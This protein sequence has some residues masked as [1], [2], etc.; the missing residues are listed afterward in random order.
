MSPR[1]RAAIC[2]LLLGVFFAAGGERAEADARAA[3]G[4]FFHERGQEAYRAGRFTEAVEHFLV[5]YRASPNPR[6][7]FNLAKAALRAERLAL[8]FTSFEE[9]LASDDDDASRREQAERHRAELV[10]RLALV[11]VTTDPP[12][13]SLYVDRRERGIAA[14]SPARVPLPASGSVEI[15]AE[16]PGHVSAHGRVEARLGQASGMHL[17]LTPRTGQLV[18]TT[19][20]STARVRVTR[21]GGG[22]VVVGD[23]I[24]LP[25][26]EYGVVVEAP[27]FSS[28]TEDGTVVASETTRLAVSLEALPRPTGR[29][30]VDS[31]VHGERVEV[32][33]REV[34]RTPL[35]LTVT[36]GQHT[37]VVAGGPPRRV[38]VE[39]ERPTYLA[40]RAAR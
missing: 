25:V 40:P 13:A 2:A 31:D 23:G 32:D 38:T 30:L 36:V 8:A 27:G 16:L 4:R 3:E 26:G 11:E 39:A 34:G 29:L 28:R 6:S 37:V 1:V 15:F 35:G 14:V 18:V 17:N 7:L 12:G 20:P 24:E 22:E 21:E 5:A 19:S 10:P 33:G 9:F